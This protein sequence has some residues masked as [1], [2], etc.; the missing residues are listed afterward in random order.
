MGPIALIFGGPHSSRQSEGSLCSRAGAFSGTFGI[1]LLAV[2]LSASMTGGSN[3]DLKEVFERLGIAVRVVIGRLRS[4]TRRERIGCLV[5][6]LW[7]FL[8]LTYRYVISA[9]V[10]LM[11]LLHGLLN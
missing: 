10:V 3:M 1:N 6:V 7:V 5:L 8:V 4:K 2:V 11:Y 9:V